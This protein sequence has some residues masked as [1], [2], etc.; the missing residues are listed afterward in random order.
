MRISD[1]SSDVC[2][3]DRTGGSNCRSNDLSSRTCGRG[4]SAWRNGLGSAPTSW[5]ACREGGRFLRHRRR[6]GRRARRSHRGGS[7]GKG[8][9]G[10]RKSVVSGKS[11]S[12]YVEHGGGRVIKKKKKKE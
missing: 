4:T 5:S 1:W 9:T 7:R 6:L 3:S 11:V 2:S 8:C 10:A 12:V